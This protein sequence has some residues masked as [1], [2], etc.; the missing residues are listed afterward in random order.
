MLCSTFFGA[1]SVSLTD[2]ASSLQ[3]AFN[4]KEPANI[5]EAV[6]LQLRLPRVLLCAFTGAILAVSGVLM[7]G[8][9]RNPIVEPGLVGTSSGAAFGASIIF[10]LSSYMSP[11]V[12]SY[13][14][15]F[16]LPVVAFLGALAATYVVYTLAK[17]AGKVSILSLLLIGIAV[18]AMCLSGTGFMSYIARDP[19][20]R[21]ITFWNLGTFSGASWL[22][23]ILVGAVGSF[24]FIFSLRDAK[25]LNALLL[26]EDE[27][28]F[29]GVD[30]EKLKR[31]I[32]LLNTA[33][34]AVVTSFV[35]VIA[36]MGLI[37]PHV[38]R[39]LI[40]SDNRRLLPASAI[41]GATL[42]TLADLTARLL[43][44]PA[45]MPIGIITSFVGAPVFI[46]LLKRFNLVLPKGGYH[47]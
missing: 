45:E 25:A 34:V 16:L 8:L 15:T 10:V 12:K 14:G 23:V 32:M 5:Y 37:V 2:I 33:M 22:Q 9:F 4:G 18:N 1:V 6:F 39:L 30:I 41:L 40:G 19:Q 38:V 24:I 36:F 46:L 27:A 3:H 42:L 28:G 7:Q 13:M 43:L 47:A 44:S 20:A 35:G 21:S 26:G 29:L 31:K 17:R 11:G